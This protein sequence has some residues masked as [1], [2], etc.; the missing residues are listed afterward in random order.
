M[1]SYGSYKRNVDIFSV[2]IEKNYSSEG[3]YDYSKTINIRTLF[4]T[5]SIHY[6]PRYS[7]PLSFMYLSPDFHEYDSGDAESLKRSY[8]EM[9]AYDKAKRKTK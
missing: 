3:T 6:S 8:D 2:D 7:R 1:S 9:V 4:G 5:F